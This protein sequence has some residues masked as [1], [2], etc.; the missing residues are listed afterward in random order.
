MLRKIYRLE[1]FLN[2]SFD[3]SLK[4]LIELVLL[5]LDAEVNSINFYE[6]LAPDNVQI[7]PSIYGNFVKPKFIYATFNYMPKGAWTNSGGHEYCNCKLKDD[8]TIIIN[9]DI[10]SNNEIIYDID[11]KLIRKF[12]LLR[13]NKTFMSKILK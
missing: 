10:S 5:D 12:K 4:L 3:D 2:D 11:I 1:P 7:G 8:T 6:K 9:W 13:L